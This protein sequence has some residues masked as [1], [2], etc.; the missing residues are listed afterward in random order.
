MKT[1]VSA[2]RLPL[3]SQGLLTHSDAPVFLALEA[4]VCCLSHLLGTGKCYSIMIPLFPQN[5][6]SS[7]D[8]QECSPLLHEPWGPRRAG[9]PLNKPNCSKKPCHGECPRLQPPGQK[10]SMQGNE[11][12]RTPQPYKNTA[13][14]T[15]TTTTTSSVAAIQKVTGAEMGAKNEKAK[16][17]HE[18]CATVFYRVCVKSGEKKHLNNT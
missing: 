7:M 15:G 2:P 14:H 3:W 10:G 9:V 4:S 17:P 13:V 1:F 16:F 5:S 18:I 6:H 11:A 12:K 8:Q